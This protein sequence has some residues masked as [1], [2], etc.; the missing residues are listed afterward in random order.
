MT[1]NCRCAL[2]SPRLN[3]APLPPL[4]FDYDIRPEAVIGVSYLDEDG[5]I[6]FQFPH[7]EAAARRICWS[8]YRRREYARQRKL[9]RLN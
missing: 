4:P 2:V 3:P 1:V 6:V 9:A 7:A 5:Q 8:L